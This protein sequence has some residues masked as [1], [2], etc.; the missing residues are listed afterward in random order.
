MLLA[1]VLTVGPVCLVLAK[2]IGTGFTYNGRLEENNHPATGDYDFEFSLYNDPCA[3]AAPNEVGAVLFFDDVEVKGGSYQVE[4]DFGNDPNIFNGQARWMEMSVRDGASI[5]PN[6]FVA[7][8][9]RMQLTAAPYAFSASRIGNKELSDLLVKDEPNGVSESMLKHGSV[10]KEK[11]GNGAVGKEKIENGAVSKEKIENGAVDPNK[12][13][14]NAVGK[15]KIKNGAVAREK[16]ENGAVD[17]NKLANNAVSREKIQNGAINSDKL[18]NS[19]VTKEKLGDISGYELNTSYSGTI[20]RL[21]NNSNNAIYAES[22]DGSGVHGVGLGTGGF[23][24]KGECPGG[25]GGTGVYG[26]SEGGIGV[27]GEIIG[28]GWAGFFEGRSAFKGSLFVT[29]TGTE[30]DPLEALHVDGKVYVEDMDSAIG[31]GYAVRWESNRL[32]IQISSARYKDNIQP[33]QDDPS[34]ILQAESKSFTFKN[35]GRGGIGFIAEEFDT[36]GLKNLVIYDKQGRPD[37]VHYELVPVY[38]LEVLKDQVQTTQQLK[39]QNESLQQRIEALERA[40]L[41]Q[42]LSSTK[43]IGQ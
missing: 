4:L 36:L 9:P 1:V 25:A 15:D 30:N 7:L 34:K 10:T 27:M 2:P 39:N 43:E 26:S 13:A 35:S 28:G 23:G 8:L 17:P 41:K 29:D 6:D 22:G 21:I 24:V 18:E 38:L 31:G 20:I 33:L 3:V 32:V 19:A 5:E 16:I 40:I 14:N 11:I 42:G 37:A 12:L